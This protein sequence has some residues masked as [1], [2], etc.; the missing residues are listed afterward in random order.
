MDLHARLA[1]AV[2]VFWNTRATQQAN[3]GSR[4]GRRDQGNR[5]AVTGG[6]QLDG[7]VQVIRDVLTEAGVADAD[8][9][10]KKRSATLPGYFRPTKEWD[11]VVV[12]DGHLLATIEF[13]SH[14]GSFGNNVNNRIEEALG[15]AL[16][17]RTAYRAGAYKPSATPWVG[18]MLL[19][20]DAPTSTRPVSVKAPHFAVLPEFRE[21][22][23]AERYRLFCERL[24]RER[25]Y[26]AACLLLSSSDRGMR[27]HYREPS[28]E[29]GFRNF[30]VSLAAKASAFHT[31]R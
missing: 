20:E 30:A 23:Y 13:K 27:G 14:V 26:D 5:G 3:Q 24:V 2:R 15:S 4:T 17:L 25:L 12:T 31:L 29:L 1:E 19:L 7:F 9:F 18:Y 22:S 16:D 6:A 21:A 10:R 8:I 28:Q 11:L